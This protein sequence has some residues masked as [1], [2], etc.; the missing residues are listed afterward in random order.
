MPS[1]LSRAADPVFLLALAVF[2]ACTDRPNPTQLPPPVE[3]NALLIDDGGGG[4]DDEPDPA[5]PYISS[6][7]VSQ[8]TLV[9]GRSSSGSYTAMLHN[10]GW[11]RDPVVMATFIRQGTTTRAAGTRAVHCGDAPSV[12]P[13]GFCTDG[14]LLSAT[15]TAS[16]T[17]TLVPGSASFQVQLKVGTTVVATRSVAVTLVYPPPIV[18]SVGQLP[19]TV[20]VPT[21]LPRQFSFTIMNPGPPSDNTYFDYFIVDAGGALL[22]GSLRGTGTLVQCARYPSPSLP[23]GTCTDSSYYSVYAPPP[24]PGPGTFGIRLTTQTGLELS[25]AGFPV[26]L[27]PAPRFT[28]T[29][30]GV[31]PDL[32]DPLPAHPD[33]GIRLDTLT[34]GGPGIPFTVFID[35]PGPSH[36]GVVLKAA[37][38]KL[39]V[40]H[41]AGEVTLVLPAGTSTASL[42][43]SAISDTTKPDP[44]PPGRAGLEIDI[45]DSHGTLIDRAIRYV[46]LVSP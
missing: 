15:N 22:A 46:M 23:T 38:Y 19:D 34:L 13:N 3:P 4:G 2:G 24:L 8:T 30:R 1:F 16:G 40:P 27:L 31:S 42:T 18:T 14:G 17:G 41:A 26:V 25:R 32:R 9:I 43:V 20:L 7:S 28:G 5:T 45:F 29:A 11:T 36:S 37:V 35:N 21:A 44:L 33:T 12:L 39:G 10:P 6:L